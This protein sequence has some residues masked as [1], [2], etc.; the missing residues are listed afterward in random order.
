MLWGECIALVSAAADQLLPPTLESVFLFVGV[1]SAER[2]AS[3][4]KRLIDEQHIEHKAHLQQFI[5][6]G[7][8]RGCSL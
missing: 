2:A 3:T 5:R 4:L 7:V 8:A 1:A 6:I